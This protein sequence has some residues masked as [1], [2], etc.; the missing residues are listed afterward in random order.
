MRTGPSCVCGFDGAS[1][2][3]QVEDSVFNKFQIARLGDL[4]RDRPH[5]SFSKRLLRNNPAPTV[6]GEITELSKIQL[7]HEKVERNRLSPR[8]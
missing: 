1:V 8:N 4:L 7:N 3:F 6:V 5:E 2:C